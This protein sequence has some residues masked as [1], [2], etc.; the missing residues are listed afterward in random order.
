MGDVRA[1][2]IRFADLWAVDEHRMVDEIYAPAIRMEGMAAPGR[3]V[4]GLD[5][6]H[7]LEA[8]LAKRV[9]EHR[10]ELVRVLVA[11]RAAFLETTVVSQATREYAQAAVWWDLDDTDRVVAEIGYF[12]WAL[13]TTDSRR[14]RG[15][16]PP[17]DQRSRGPGEWYAAFVERL[18]AELRADPGATLERWCAADCA[19]DVIGRGAFAGVAAV[20]AAAVGAV[21]SLPGATVEVLRVLAEGGVVAVLVRLRSGYRS[22][23]GTVVLTLDG[24]DRVVGAR[25]YLDWSKAQADVDAEAPA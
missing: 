7:A 14:S 10:H 23:R 1:V 17:D 13:R 8:E 2:A 20:R 6:L 11:G 5:E 3:R 21:A 16:V 24:D 4:D 15:T 19:A 22:T 18:V 12:D 9:P 25:L